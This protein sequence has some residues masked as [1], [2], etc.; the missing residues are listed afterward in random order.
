MHLSPVTTAGSGYES[1][2]YPK[3]QIELEKQF[4]NR[5]SCL[6]YLKSL[7]WPNGFVCSRCH[8]SRAWEQSRERLTCADCKYET[9]IL[10]GTLF[11]SSHV[12]L[13]IWFRAAWWMTN[14]K[15]GVSALGLQRALGIGSYRTSWT[16]LH[17][18]RSSMIRPGRDRLTGPVE[19]D[20]AVIGGHQS[21][22]A[23]KQSKWN[24]QFVLIAAE[25]DGK[26]TGRIRLKVIANN[27]GPTLNVAIQELIEPG[28]E[29]ITDGLKGYQ[30]MTAI[31]YVHTQIVTD[32][33]L[34]DQQMLP[35]AHRVASLLKRWLNGTH[36][37]R[38]ND[39]HLE[40]YLQEFVFRFNRRTSISRGLLFHRLI[41]QAVKA[42][43]KPSGKIKH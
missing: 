27:Q 3:N 32:S 29:I 18:L 40:A 31:G 16:L 24:K 20:E 23:R 19:M 7:R 22:K 39:K 9:S 30:C 1:M 5:D 37:G 2:H 15:Q 17:K 38:A 43:P 33:I 21:A 28:S 26:K 36:H 35:R 25:I 41:E 13:E 12:P 11:Q 6:A 34:D 8:G 10:A 4:S 42:T 14:Q